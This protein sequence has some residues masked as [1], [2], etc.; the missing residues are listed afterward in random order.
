MKIL[1]TSALVLGAALALV[2]CATTNEIEGHQIRADGQAVT[3]TTYSPAIAA[4]PQ[5]FRDGGRRYLNDADGRY[6]VLAVDRN[7]RGWSYVY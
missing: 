5:L 3:T 7:A 1:T 2:A 6:A 4:A